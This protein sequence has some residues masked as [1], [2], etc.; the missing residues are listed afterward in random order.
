MTQASHAIPSEFLE[1]PARYFLEWIP[2]QLEAHDGAHAHFG[3]VNA[4]AQFHLTGESGGHW[5]FTLDRTGVH[6]SEGLHPNPSF[7]LTMPVPIWRRINEGTYNGLKAYLRRDLQFAGSR[8]KF[9]R[10]ARLFS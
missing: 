10:V 9:L 5:Y 3:K 4:I 1:H 8:L 6:V 7:T 2:Q